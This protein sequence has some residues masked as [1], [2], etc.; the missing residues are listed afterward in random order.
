[1][2][3]MNS[4]MNQSKW[5]ESF[6][7]FLLVYW[8][9]LKQQEI[10]TVWWTALVL[11][12]LKS[13]P[14]WHSVIQHCYSW[15]NKKMCIFSIIPV[16]KQQFLMRLFEDNM[17]DWWWLRRDPL[18]IVKRFV[19]TAIHNKELYKCLIHSFIHSFIHLHSCPWKTLGVCD[20]GKNDISM[21]FVSF[22]I[23]IIKICFAKCVF[24]LYLGW[25]RPVMN[26]YIWLKLP[27]AGAKS[28]SK[29]LMNCSFKC[30]IQNFWF[31]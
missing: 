9:P 22:S 27:V 31:I 10:Q 1:M 15:W 17:S 25:F 16:L 20:I 29:W 7:S 5:R 4:K 19:C 3:K 23:T 14:L 13:H 12:R 26:K 8:P 2:F 21:S 6:R 30:F 18:M 11:Q 24:V 28:L